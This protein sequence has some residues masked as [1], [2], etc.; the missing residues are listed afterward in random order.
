MTKNIGKVDKAAR[1]VVGVILIVLGMM[2]NSLLGLIGIIPIV[3]AFL[4]TCPLY[5]LLNMNTCNDK[6]ES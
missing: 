2:T 4:G 6:F 1:I 5:T 3:T